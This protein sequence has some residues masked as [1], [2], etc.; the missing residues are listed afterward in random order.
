MI[1]FVVHKSELTLKAAKAAPS[2]ASGL[3]LSF[4]AIRLV[5]GRA[6]VEV[7]ADVAKVGPKTRRPNNEANLPNFP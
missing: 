1:L 6:S 2:P 3:L 4:V 5:G 7:D